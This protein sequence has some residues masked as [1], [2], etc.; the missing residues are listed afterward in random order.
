MAHLA[1]SCDVIELRYVHDVMFSIMKRRTKSN[2]LAPF[3]E[4]KSGEHLK[5]KII[6]DIYN[7]YCLGEGSLSLPK[8]MLQSESRFVSQEVQTNNVLSK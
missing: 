3:I 5:D 6:K 8:H 1:D 4:K 7:L 2:Q